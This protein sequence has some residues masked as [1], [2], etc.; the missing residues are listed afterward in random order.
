MHMK[1]SKDNLR[2]QFVPFTMGSVIKLRSGLSCLEDQG[3]CFYPWSESSCSLAL[4][5]LGC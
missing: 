1:K 3:K 2:S 4:L 5:L